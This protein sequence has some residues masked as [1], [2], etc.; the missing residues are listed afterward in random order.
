MKIERSLDIPAKSEVNEEPVHARS[1]RGMLKDP[2]PGMI[3]R[4]DRG[5]AFVAYFGYGSLVNR[6][7][8]RTEIVDMVPARLSGWRRCWR[9]RPDMPGFPAAL[10]TVLLV[11]LHAAVKASSAMMRITDNFRNI[12]FT[13]G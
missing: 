9:H 7:T 4:D 3:T 8:L 2:V 13:P 12:R 5:S 10:L 6:A 11:E 1:G